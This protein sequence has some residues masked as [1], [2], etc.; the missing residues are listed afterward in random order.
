MIVSGTA[1]RDF[2]QL[3]FNSIILQYKFKSLKHKTHSKGALTPSNIHL[4]AYFKGFIS[5]SLL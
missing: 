4:K 2:L 5:L 3:Y 1:I